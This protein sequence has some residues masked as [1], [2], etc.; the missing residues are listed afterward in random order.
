MP[1]ILHT[2]DW[3]I[4][5]QYGRF[6]PEDAATLAEARLSAVERLSLIHI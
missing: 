2:A 1:K 5:R 3:Q 6:A 4:G